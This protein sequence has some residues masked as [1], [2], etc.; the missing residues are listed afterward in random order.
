[1]KLRPAVT[2]KYEH[3]RQAFDAA[4][5][6]CRLIGSLDDRKHRFVAAEEAFQAFAVIREAGEV[7]EVITVRPCA[8]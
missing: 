8:A 7:L 1:M 5:Q 4:E 3:G 2:A 6:I